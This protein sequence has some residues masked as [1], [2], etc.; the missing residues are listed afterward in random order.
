MTK[1]QSKG[2]NELLNINLSKLMLIQ[3]YHENRRAKN[4]VNKLR[5]KVNIML[6]QKTAD[7]ATNAQRTK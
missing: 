2:F 4:Y 7:K 5:N 6:V 3:E 1:R